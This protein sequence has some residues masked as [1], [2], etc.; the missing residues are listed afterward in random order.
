MD[1]EAQI[2]NKNLEIFFHFK[3]E[4]EMIKILKKLKPYSKTIT[5][6]LIID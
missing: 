1:S 5:H 2:K 6:V 4:K 3:N